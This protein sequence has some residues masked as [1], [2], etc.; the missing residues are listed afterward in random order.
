MLHKSAVSLILFTSVFAGTVR[1]ANAASPIVLPANVTVAPGQCA[2]FA[3]ALAT[4]ASP[5]D[6]SVTLSS[7]DPSTV[8]LALSPQ[9]SFVVVIPAGATVPDRRTPNALV[10]G[11][12]FGSALINAA[13]TGYSSASQTV[14][15]FET[16]SFFP[17]NVIEPN[18]SKQVR[19][20]LNETYPALAGGLTVSVSSDNPAVGT[21]PSTVTI[22]AGATG[23]TVPVT[24]VSAGT[25]LIHA[26]GAPNAGDAVASVT[27]GSGGT[28]VI[29][30]VKPS[31]GQQGQQTLSVTITG[32]L[33]HFVQGTTTASFGAGITIASL[34]VSSAT[35]ATA[36]LNIDPAAATG[37][38]NVTLTTGAEVATLSNGFTVTA[39]ILVPSITTVS[40]AAAQQGQGGP[41]TVVG[42][43]THFVQGTSVLDLGPGITVSNVTVTCLTCLSAQ[44]AITD[45]AA[46]GARNVT[47]TTGAEVATLVNGFTVQPGNP[48]LTSLVPASGKQGQSFPVTMTG[49]FTHWVQGTT[50]VSFGAGVTVSNVTVS[51]AT[52][53]TAQLSIDAAAAIGTRT[54]TVTTGTEIVSVADIFTVQSGLSSVTPAPVSG[55]QAQALTVAITGQF[56]HFVQGTTTVTFGAGI[57]VGTVTVASSTSL[58][59]QITIAENAATGPRT[60]TV[61]TG[62]EIVTAPNAFTVNLGTIL[63]SLNPGGAYQ[64]QTLSVAITGQLTNFV[65][66]ITQATFGP[67]IAVG[68]AAEGGFGPVTVTGATAATAQIVVNPA[69]TPGLRTVSAQTGAEIASFTNGFSVVAPFIIT[70]ITPNSAQVGQQN[71]TVAVVGQTTHFVQNTSVLDLGAGV[72]INSLTVTDATH[73]TAVISVAANAIVAVRDVAVTTGSEFA[74]LRAGFTVTGPPSISSISPNNGQLGQTNVP[75]TIVGQNTHFTNAS[76][77]DLGAGV[78]VSGVTATNATHIS[79]QITIAANATPGFRTLTV[80]TG[81]EV[82]T[83]ANGFGV[84]PA[85]NQAPVITIAPTWSVTLPARLTINYTVTDDGL[86]AGGALTVTWD[87]IAGPGTVGYTGQTTTS[88]SVGFSDPGTYTLRITATDTQFTVHQDVTVTVSGNVV[89]PPA[90]S[91]ISPTEGTEVTASINVTGTVTST[92]LASWSLEMRMQEESVFRPFATGTTQVT[93]GILGSFDPTLLLNGIALIQLRATDTGGQT[94]IAGP[95]SVVLTKNL[96]IGNFT[97]SFNDL[98]VPVAGLPIQVVRTYDSRN[99]LVGDFG[100]GWTLD[101]KTVRLGTNGPLGDNWT[102]TSSGGAFP[103]Y[104]LQALKAHVVTVSFNDGTTYEF[105]PA[106][107]PQC[108]QFVPIQDEPVAMTFT[109]MGI[110]PPN[111]ALAVLGLQPFVT[112][113]VPGPIAMVDQDTLTSFDPDQYL[114]TLPDGRVLQISR[115]SGQIGRASCRERV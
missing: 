92:A 75:V 19:L 9:N 73:L 11:V 39:I 70:S 82:V 8:S 62:T 81:T 23:V 53:L 76:V 46:T 47:V 45:T 111:A 100:V 41:M 5:G 63:L 12:K 2:P 26:S 108:R 17:S 103:T 43:N 85:G 91:I 42:L 15:V 57:T 25:T 84:N 60:V 107:S 55:R 113:S 68:G 48:I 1:F 58:A 31:S 79:A 104:C 114:L 51:S 7:G 96:K 115:A 65:Q 30:L 40:P 64:N 66:G 33:S 36:V 22:P 52:S 77:V 90:V 110:T 13:A 59:A 34:T 89:P 20:T 69:A 14:R 80:T 10:C 6:V 56:T 38:R 32:A 95:V 29:T 74:L 109:P 102:E 21:V 16:L 112:G 35:S 105:Q 27:F 99:K 44:V 4:P 106:L 49:K 67:G 61:T 71:L 72:T 37:A 97:V 83:L 78:T 54:P 18:L 98:S 28:P 93:N 88:I 94:S 24:G 86:P 50:Q 87:T 3:V 101:L